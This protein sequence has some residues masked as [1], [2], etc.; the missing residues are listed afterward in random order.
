MYKVGVKPTYG[1]GGRFLRDALDLETAMSWA[2]QF[3]TDEDSTLANRTA[4]WRR[5]AEKPSEQQRDFAERLGLEFPENITKRDLSDM[6]SIHVASRSLDRAIK[7][8]T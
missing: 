3:A 4:S 8:R 7:A 1:S 6:I 5:R 2:E